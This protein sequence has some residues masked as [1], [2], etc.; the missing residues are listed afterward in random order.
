MIANT[1]RWWNSPQATTLLKIISGTAIVVAAVLAF[2]MRCEFGVK[3]APTIGL[4][5]TADHV[6]YFSHQGGQMVVALGKQLSVETGDA[7][8]VDARGEA[9]LHFPDFQ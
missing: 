8:D 3:C 5:A 9:L 4:S 1:L 7:I 6:T 2:A